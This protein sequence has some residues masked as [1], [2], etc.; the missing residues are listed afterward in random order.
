MNITASRPRPSSR[1][2]QDAADIPATYEN[3]ELLASP[4]DVRKHMLKVI[5]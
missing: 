2:D 1:L 3:D 4:E 5:F